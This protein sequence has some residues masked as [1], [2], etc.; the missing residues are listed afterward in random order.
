M[1]KRQGNELMAGLALDALVAA[2]KTGSMHGGQFLSMP[3]MVDS[4]G[5]P[6]A[7][8][9]EAV[10]Q[11]SSFGLVDIIPKRGVKVMETDPEMTRD[12][13]DL[14]SI[15]DQEGA[16]RLIRAGKRLDLRGLRDAHVRIRD[17]AANKAAGSLTEKAIKTDLSLH[18]FL[19]SGLSN[20]IAEENYAVNRIRIA[21]IQNSR[22]FVRKRIVSAMDEHLDIID[23]LE[24]RDAGK[25]VHAIEMHY[26]NT[27]EWWGV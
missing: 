14:R 12:C 17:L 8:V 24:A 15:L 9:R 27:R 21:I 6:I 3:Q 11:A 2:L 16:R 18:D 20:P 1:V 26:E 13:L 4:L 23:A 7:A 19:S 5:F 22:P 10:K 25:A